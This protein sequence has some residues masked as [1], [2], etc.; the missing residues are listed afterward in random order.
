MKLLDFLSVFLLPFVLFYILVYGLLQKKP[1]FELFIKGGKQGL[2][3]V[4]ELAPTIVGL[5]LA[6]GVFRSSGAL[7][8]LC[9]LLAPLGNLLRIPAA[10]LPLSIIKMFS[11]SGANGLLFD[12]FK[13]YGTDS[14]IGFTASLLLSCT[15][16]LFYT[17]S[18]YF[19]S[20][21]I[22]KT[23][24]CV[25]AGLILA[26]LSLLISTHIAGLYVASP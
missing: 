7:D 8:H 16:T 13:S 15:E 18:I 23:R 22:K 11:A 25:P 9:R 20:V 3:T 5:L 19:M 10:I 24:W 2:H 4:C 14:Y 26:L 12:L 21:G 1:I 17:L 6:V